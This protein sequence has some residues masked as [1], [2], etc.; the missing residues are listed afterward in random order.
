MP[1]KFI[2]L[3]LRNYWSRNIYKINDKLPE[4]SSKI[5]GVEKFLTEQISYNFSSMYNKH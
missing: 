2:K 3:G 5:Y 4:G 1:F